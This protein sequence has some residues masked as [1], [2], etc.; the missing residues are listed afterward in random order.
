MS[1]RT[2][3]TAPPP[4][5]AREAV[6]RRTF[7]SQFD[8]PDDRVTLERFGEL[9]LTLALAGGYLGD[10]E[11]RLL[12][13][14]LSGAAEDL[15]ELAAY[16]QELAAEPLHSEVDGEDLEV[17]RLARDIAGRIDDVISQTREGLREIEGGPVPT[18][19]GDEVREAEAIARRMA[20]H[21]PDAEA[22][23]TY[24]WIAERAAAKA[25]GKTS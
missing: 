9:L 1:D 19:L 17:C 5:P 8:D 14:Q 10:R 22:R 15:D 2:K 23:K 18:L 12:V 3:S 6:F 24:R 16:C 4:A 25:K 11:Q 20:E 21:H 13:S 7:L